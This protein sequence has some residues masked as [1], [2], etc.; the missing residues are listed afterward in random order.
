MEDVTFETNNVNSNRIE[1]ITRTSSRK[2]RKSLVKKKMSRRV[3][4]SFMINKRLSLEL[5]EEAK[6][7]QMLISFPSLWSSIWPQKI[8]RKTRTTPVVTI[9]MCHLKLA[10]LIMCLTL[11]KSFISLSAHAQN[12]HN[13]YLSHFNYHQHRQEPLDEMLPVE[14]TMPAYSPT[15]LPI[16]HTHYRHQHSNRPLAELEPEPEQAPTT[17]R[18]Q[19]FGLSSNLEPKASSS[20]TKFT[21]TNELDVFLDDINHSELRAIAAGKP[22][23]DL[24][25]PKALPV[26]SAPSGGASGAKQEAQTGAPAGSQLDS[27]G[28][29]Q[30]IYSEC[31]LILQRTYVKNINDPK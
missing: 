9:T 3:G 1:D 21:R 20:S 16:N 29:E 24:F 25:K 31:A 13:H 5:N 8:K 19:V 11:V 18:Q 12:N 27:S 14:I 23:N 17:T 6:K 4:I 22:I 26:S 30:Q 15:R 7:R 2:K 28:S 10:V